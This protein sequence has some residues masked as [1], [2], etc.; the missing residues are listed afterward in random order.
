MSLK[1]TANGMAPRPRGAKVYHAPRGRG[2][3]PSSAA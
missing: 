1:R 2:A 3:M